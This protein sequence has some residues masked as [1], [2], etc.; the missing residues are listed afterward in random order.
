MCWF[1]VAQFHQAPLT[2]EEVQLDVL[3]CV[4]GNLA[5]VSV[6]D[7]RTSC[8]GNHMFV[9]HGEHS[10]KLSLQHIQCTLWYHLSHAILYSHAD[11]CI[12]RHP[13]TCRVNT[14]YKISTYLHA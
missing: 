3:L 9:E 13:Q 11:C 14:K 4:L 8:E 6:V 12:T 1:F 2:I 10:S 7:I 5:A